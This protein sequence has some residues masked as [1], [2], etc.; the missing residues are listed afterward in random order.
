[1]STHLIFK[2]L[3]N[4]AFKMILALFIF[5]SNS[6]ITSGQSQET[7]Y[8]TSFETLQTLCDNILLRDTSIIRSV[9][10]NYGYEVL[11]KERG[12][13]QLYVDALFWKNA[14]ETGRVF[15]SEKIE[16]EEEY[17]LLVEGIPYEIMVIT[18]YGVDQLMLIEKLT[19]IWE[20]NEWKFAYF[21]E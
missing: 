8:K 1:M 7:P 19:F 11:M 20:E 5:L 4:S 12:M 18:S 16:S 17:K 14:M 21:S 9:S 2:M 10:T 3:K 6:G 15:V 13:E